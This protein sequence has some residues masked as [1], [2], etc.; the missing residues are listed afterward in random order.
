MTQPSDRWP[1]SALRTRRRNDAAHGS[2]PGVRPIR[3]VVPTGWQ[4][5]LWCLR[6][7]RRHSRR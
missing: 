4:P 5:A 1:P 3:V 2:V 7:G 6:E